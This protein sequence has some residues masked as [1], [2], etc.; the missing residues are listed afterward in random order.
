MLLEDWEAIKSQSLPR[1]KDWVRD[2]QDHLLFLE[3]DVS[4]E[5]IASQISEQLGFTVQVEDI[6]RC[7]R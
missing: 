4:K 3:V 6:K 7:D 5:L 2:N 1:R